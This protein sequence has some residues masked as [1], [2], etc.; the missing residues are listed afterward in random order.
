VTADEADE[1]D[2]SRIASLKEMGFTTE[3]VKNALA[4]CNDDVNDALTLLLSSR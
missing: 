4:Q 2:D 1:F 3:E